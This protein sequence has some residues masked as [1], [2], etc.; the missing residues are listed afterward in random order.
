MNRGERARGDWAEKGQGRERGGEG[1]ILCGH[2]ETG[3]QSFGEVWEHPAAA[4][5]CAHDSQICD[6]H[7][8]L[9]SGC[10]LVR[11][12]RGGEGR[13][14]ESPVQDSSSVALGER[15][16]R[17]DKRQLQN[18]C[19]MISDEMGGGIGGD[20]LSRR[21]PPLP[22]PLPILIF[23]PSP[24]SPRGRRGGPG[25]I[26]V[27]VPL[28]LSGRLLVTHLFLDLIQ[29]AVLYRLHGEADRSITTTASRSRMEAALPSREQQ[30]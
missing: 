30:L 21:S 27:A 26:Q 11:E 22:L 28:P 16:W 23:V 19:C 13:G 17:R 2:R 9:S 8:P 29:R 3:V 14:G 1:L 18:V 25:E 4:A 12:G 7:T 10:W 6:V 15:S 5:G 20:F 24:S